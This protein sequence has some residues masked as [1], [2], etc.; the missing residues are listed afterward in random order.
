M[1]CFWDALRATLNRAELLAL[2][3]KSNARQPQ[4]ISALKRLNRTTPNVLWQGDKLRIREQKENLKHVN[5]YNSSEY[6]SGYLTSSADPFLM[7]CAEIFLWEIDFRFNG[8][9]IRIRHSQ[10]FRVVKFKA[11]RTHFEKGG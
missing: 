3:L 11:S 6:R 10:P 4:L 7:L 5:E 8:S 2:G 9:L 1:S